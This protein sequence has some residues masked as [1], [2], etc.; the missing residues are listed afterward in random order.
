MT[1]KRTAD[2]VVVGGGMMG[3]ATAYYLK[4]LGM[5]DVIL[6]EK[7]TAASGATGRCAAAFR[8]TWGGEL[9]IILGKA[10]IDKYEH[11]SEELGIYVFT[12]MATY[13]WPTPRCAA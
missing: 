9:N 5:K 13:L 2:A 7:K 4:K 11:L 1:W 12:R 6:I 3:M 8:A 10:C